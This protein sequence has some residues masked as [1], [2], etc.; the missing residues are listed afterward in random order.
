MA[1]SKMCYSE[2]SREWMLLNKA[3]FLDPREI[4]SNELR[5]ISNSFELDFFSKVTALV[6][7]HFNQLVPSSMFQQLFHTCPSF[8]TLSL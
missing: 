5:V 6:D 3:A 8:L 4:H 7:A 1:N 2:Q